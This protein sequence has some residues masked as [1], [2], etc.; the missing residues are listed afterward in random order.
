MPWSGPGHEV[1]PEIPVCDVAV[2]RRMDREPRPAHAPAARARFPRCPSG[3]EW[4]PIHREVERGLQLKKFGNRLL[5]IMGGRAIHPINVTVG[6]FYRL[7]R[8]EN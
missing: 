7:P 3:I 6:G 1:T 4:R 5:D 8:R 2:L